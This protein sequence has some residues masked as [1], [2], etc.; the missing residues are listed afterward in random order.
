MTPYVKRLNPAI[1]RMAEDML[2]RG[3]AIS[4]M[5]SYTY[6][7]DR[8]SRHF[9]KLPIVL[10]QDEV[11]AL[12]QCARHPKHRAVLLTFHSAGLRLSEVASGRL[13]RRLA[14]HGKSIHSNA[15]TATTNQATNDSQRR[16]NSNRSV[17]NW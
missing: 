13:L 11:H 4:T 2:L 6:H 16:S 7:L 3:I 14:E 1:K 12:I 9:G 17:I 8:F 5:D 15:T 10:G